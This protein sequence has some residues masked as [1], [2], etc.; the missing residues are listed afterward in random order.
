MLSG[1]PIPPKELSYDRAPNPISDT[2]FE[3][4]ENLT[5]GRKGN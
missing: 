1:K 5:S 2:E 3:V 4:I